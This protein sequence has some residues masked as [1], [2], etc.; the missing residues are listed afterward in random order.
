MAAPLGVGSVQVLARCEVPLPLLRNSTLSVIGERP[1]HMV[2][3]QGRGRPHLGAGY[4]SSLRVLCCWISACL[5]SEA[6]TQ[7]AILVVS[8]TPP[9]RSITHRS[10]PAPAAPLQDSWL[11]AEAAAAHKALE[12]I[13]FSPQ[14]WEKAP[15]LLVRAARGARDCRP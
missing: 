14:S 11:A 15:S 10:A 9:A 1:E 5:A 8:F 7:P 3:R 12:G 13:L 4:L 6:S 2:R